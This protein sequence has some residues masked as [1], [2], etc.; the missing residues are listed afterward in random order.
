[1]TGFVATGKVLRRRHELV[2][3]RR[4]QREKQRKEKERRRQ[5][6]DLYSV[7]KKQGDD[8]QQPA[9]ASVK[10]EK[11]T[12]ATGSQK[13]VAGGEVSPA[14]LFTEITELPLV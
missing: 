1:M 4:W 9:H 7:A 12:G 2:G 5:R 13:K 8:T 6:P 3:V 14:V 11:A 10:P